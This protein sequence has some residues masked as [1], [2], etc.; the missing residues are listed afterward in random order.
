MSLSLHSL[1]HYENENPKVRS[2]LATS[3]SKIRTNVLAVYSK[4]VG[5]IQGILA[6]RIISLLQL[7]KYGITTIFQKEDTVTDT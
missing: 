6:H 1:Y 2:Y 4:P 5:L 7:R 3:A